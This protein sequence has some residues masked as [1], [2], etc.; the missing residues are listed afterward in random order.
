MTT[1]NAVAVFLAWSGLAANLIVMFAV[2][3]KKLRA[4]SEQIDIDLEICHQLKL[5]MQDFLSRDPQLVEHMEL[6]L[7]KVADME[8]D[9]SRSKAAL[10]LLRRVRMV[11][12]G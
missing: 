1:S 8:R 2:W 3:P 9:L 4:L 10:A 5:L 7:L 11:R 6:G 12:G